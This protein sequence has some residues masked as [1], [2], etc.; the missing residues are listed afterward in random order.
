MTTAAESLSKRSLIVEVSWA[1]QNVIDQLNQE[2]NPGPHIHTSQFDHN[3]VVYCKKKQ[4]T[5][6]TLIMFCNVVH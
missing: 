6:G 3:R 2:L 4:K 1:E 5:Q